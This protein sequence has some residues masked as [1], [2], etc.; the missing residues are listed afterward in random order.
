MSFFRKSIH[1][2]RLTAIGLLV[3]V[4]GCLL[5]VVPH[6]AT[7]VYNPGTAAVG[8]ETCGSHAGNKSLNVSAAPRCR[9]GE[10]DDKLSWYLYI[11]V[12][13]QILQ[14]M[15]TVPL[16]TI[17][18]IFLDDVVTRQK[19]PLYIGKYGFRFPS[20]P[21]TLPYSDIKI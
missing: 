19:F 11:F 5:F 7:G 3:T 14:G 18:I 15:C 8:T 1:R 2:P 20:I 9:D 21:L 10:G 6:F 12:M 4:I 13:A 17:G 16:Q